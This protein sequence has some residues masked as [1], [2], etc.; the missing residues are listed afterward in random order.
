MS[1][2]NLLQEQL[3]ADRLLVDPGNGRTVLPDRSPAILSVSEAGATSRVLGTP[4]RLGQ[5]LIVAGNVIGGNLTIT[6][7]GSVAINSSGNTT[8]TIAAAGRSITFVAIAVANV[9]R[10]RVFSND[11]ATLS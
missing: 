11:G 8:A 1:A 2:H 5:M 10:W 6:Q 4:E 7:T 3:L 9:L